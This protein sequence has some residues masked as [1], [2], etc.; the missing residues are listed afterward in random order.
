MAYTLVDPPVTPY[1]SIEELRAWVAECERRVR[2]D[3]P[4][5]GWVA[6]LDQAR[7]WLDAAQTE[8][9]GG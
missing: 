8:R 5:A 3:P 1:S 6:A 7:A 2:D 9:G 4:D